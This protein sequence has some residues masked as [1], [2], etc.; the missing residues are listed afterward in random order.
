MLLNLTIGELEYL[1]TVGESSLS[2]LGIS[3]VVDN[4]SIRESLLYVFVV[5]EDHRVGIGEYFSP[6]SV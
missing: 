1:E 6:D 5:E 2:S 3:E 4:F